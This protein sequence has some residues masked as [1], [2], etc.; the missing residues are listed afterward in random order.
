M[1]KSTDPEIN[2]IE[3]RVC[4]LTD[5][6]KRRYATPQATQGQSGGRRNKGKMW[7]RSLL[8]FLWEGTGE[9]AYADWLFLIVSV[10]SVLFL[11]VWHLAL[12][13]LEQGNIGQECKNFIEEMV[14]GMASISV[15]IWKA[16]WKNLAIHCLQEL[17]NPGRGSPSSVSKA[18]KMLKHQKYR[19]KRQSNMMQAQ[20]WNVLTWLGLFPCNVFVHQETS[21]CSWGYRTTASGAAVNPTQG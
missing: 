15:C 11:V 19:I 2:A 5:I 6:K 17:A 8:W 13:W 7:A 9:A 21:S 14:R 3:E 10:G 20:A 18:P 4:S 12:G 1:A 16:Y